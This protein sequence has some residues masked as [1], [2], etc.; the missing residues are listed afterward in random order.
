MEQKKSLTVKHWDN[1]DKPREKLIDQGK[2][3]LSN[4]ELIAILLRS[5]LPGKSVVEVAR[6]VLDKA[7][8]SLTA[9]S[10]MEFNQ[11]NCIRGMAKAKSATLMAALELGWRMQGEINSGRE[12]FI[13]DSESLFKLLMPQL[14]DLDHEEFWAVFL[15]VHHKVIGTQRIAMCGQTGTPIDLRIL[16]RNAIENKAVYFAVAHNHPSGSLHPSAE[17]RRLTKNISEPGKLLD[18]NLIEHLV[19]G[20][21]TDGGADY[22]SFHDNG[23]L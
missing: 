18:I 20:I 15:N 19:I 14:V 16:F 9:L 22:Y 7:G 2:K 11:L 5:G 1:K 17:D 13:K 12:T 21:T 3:Q 10:R 6:E 23:L 4:V 8:N